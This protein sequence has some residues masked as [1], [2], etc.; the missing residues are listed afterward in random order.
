L[1]QIT[2]ELSAHIGGQP[3][4]PQRYLIERTAVDIVRLEL[5]DA[6]MAAGTIS[7]HDAR[8]AHALRNSVRLSLRELGLQPKPPPAPSLAEHFAKRAAERAAAEAAPKG[9]AA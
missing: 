7:D 8:V 5:F 4:A 2:R 9:A 3:S 1:R 6:E